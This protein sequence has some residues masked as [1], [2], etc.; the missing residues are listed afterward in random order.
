MYDDLVFDAG[1]YPMSPVSTDNRFPNSKS[2]SN[3]MLRTRRNCDRQI[4]RLVIALAMP[5]RLLLHSPGTESDPCP[6]VS[7]TWCV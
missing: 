7:L 5:S 2:A 4:T 3:R 6:L 1:T